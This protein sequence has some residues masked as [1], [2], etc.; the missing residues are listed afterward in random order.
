MFVCSAMQIMAQKLVNDFLVSVMDM[1]SRPRDISAL[2]K[3]CRPLYRA[4]PRYLLRRG[5][6]IRFARTLVSFLSFMGAEGGA[7]L[8]HLKEL[9]IDVQFNI[10]NLAGLLS[11]FID[12]YA[13]ALVISTLHI[14]DA[15][16][17]LGA[18]TPPLSN[19]FARLRTITNLELLGVGRHAASFLRAMESK[20]ET[21]HLTMLYWSTGPDD[22]IELDN[23]DDR[24]VIT[25]LH[26]SQNTLRRL[27][28]HGLELIPPEDTDPVYPQVY[29]R[30]EQLTLSG[31]DC[32]A[33]I[34]YAHAFP[35]IRILHYETAEED[36]DM[37]RRD[38]DAQVEIRALNRSQQMQ[39]ESPWK[40]LDACHANLIDLFLLGLHC[41]VRKLYVLGDFKEFMPLRAVLMDTTPD[42]MC[43]QGCAVNIFTRRLVSVMEA[44]Y[45]QQLRSLEIVLLVDSVHKLEAL[46]MPQAVVRL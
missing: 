14:N 23:R 20:L 9:S 28:A 37:I 21:A 26:G 6:H 4:G 36:L 8:K 29:P 19:T 18:G 39:L 42:Y 13:H 40:S 15:E 44:T 33:T 27:T 43:L 31:N 5:V 2:M 32:P 12:R 3:T 25:L 45:A 30:V 17:L 46:N 35:N 38:V 1:I 24:N 7:R 16:A 10:S 41:H 11:A 22:D 34:V